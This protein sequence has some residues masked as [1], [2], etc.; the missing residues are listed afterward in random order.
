MDHQP[1]RSHV[2]AHLSDYGKTHADTLL[3]PDTADLSSLAAAAAVVEPYS[4]QDE[5]EIALKFISHAAMYTYD[6]QPGR[7]KSLVAKDNPHLALFA[8]VTR[9]PSKLIRALS[10]Q[11]CTISEHLNGDKRLTKCQ[12][13]FRP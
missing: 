12:I 13:C 2:F 3:Q 4:Y 7:F 8:S 6:E 9:L 11:L 10:L 1:Q 5:A